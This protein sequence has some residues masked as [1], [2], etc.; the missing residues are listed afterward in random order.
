MPQVVD[1]ARSI[2]SSRYGA[3]T[4]FGDDGH[5]SDFIVSGLT[6]EERQALWDMPEG[7]G[8]FEYLSELN[9]PLRVSDLD[10]HLKALDMPDFLPGISVT[11]L[12]VAPVRHQE[13]GIVTTCLA[14]ETKGRWFSREYIRVSAGQGGLEA[15][16]PDLPGV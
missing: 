14:H 8:F 3:I 15:H 4:V 1:E 7:E 10:S 13:V 12:L 5:P 16:L 2:T 11:S 6:P 9:E